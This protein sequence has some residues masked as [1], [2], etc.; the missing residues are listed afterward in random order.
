V[1]KSKPRR[2]SR[3]IKEP[4]PLE[5]LLAELRTLEMTLGEVL[6]RVGERLRT[7]LL[8][9]S[10]TVAGPT[11]NDLGIRRVEALHKAIRALDVNPV[12]GRVKDLLRLRDLLN[13]LQERLSAEP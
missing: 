6:D 1:G 9:I 11:G 13:D 4:S 8:A 7:R 3:H 5:L 2:P 12:K 10:A